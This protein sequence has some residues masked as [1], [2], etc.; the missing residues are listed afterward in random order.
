MLAGGEEGLSCPEHNRDHLHYRDCAGA[1]T[2]A[3]RSNAQRSW[4]ARVARA[5]SIGMRT[6][7][8]SDSPFVCV[9]SKKILEVKGLPGKQSI[10]A[11]SIDANRV[12]AEDSGSRKH[13]PAAPERLGVDR[14]S[15]AS[16]SAVTGT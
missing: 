11:N 9:F 3:A 16:T 13:N 1:S 2:A 12:T 15:G 5:P 6:S 4:N 7:P 8:R 14:P 10:E